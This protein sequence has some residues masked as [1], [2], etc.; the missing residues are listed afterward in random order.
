MN[1]KSYIISGRRDHNIDEEI[2]NKAYQH[3]KK[4]W[5]PEIFN[6][7]EFCSDYFIKMQNLFVIMSDDRVAA[8]A[9]FNFYDLSQESDRDLSY[10]QYLQKAGF[11]EKSKKNPLLISGEY[12]SRHPIFSVKNTGISLGS[13]L[14]GMIQQA[15]IHSI[16]DYILGTTFIFRGVDQMAKEFGFQSVANIDRFGIPCAIVL[17]TRE[18][19]KTHPD[20]KHAY[21]IE[22]LWN[23]SI[24]LKIYNS[25]ETH[26]D[27]LTKSI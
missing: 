19:A 20:A 5:I 9:A 27:K 6:K 3:W 4:I 11:F 22:E 16:A 21:L 13:I 15:F 23:T 14:I 17:N 8:L 7:T 12:I 24:N 10:I 2:Y 18:G 1:F 25:Q 26:Y